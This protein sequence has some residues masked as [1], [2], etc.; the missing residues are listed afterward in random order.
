M[1]DQHF[2]FVAGSYALTA[3]VLAWNWLAPRLAR[4]RLR[5]RLREAAAEEPGP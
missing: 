1:S 2:A 3:A 5:D 4:A